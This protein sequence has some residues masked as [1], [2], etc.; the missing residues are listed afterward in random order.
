[1]SIVRFAFLLPLLLWTAPSASP[2][3]PARGLFRE[4]R[5]VWPQGRERERNLFVGFRATFGWEGN[6]QVT[7]RL[8]ASTLY[9]A[10]VNGRFA[11]YGPARGPHGYDRVD[12]WDV[13]PFLS[14][15]KSNVVAVEVAG[16]N[17]NSYYTLDAPSFFRAE[18][19]QGEQVL[20]STGGK[21]G[22]FEAFI[23]PERVQKVQRYSFQ[24][25]FS[26]VYRL[27][28]GWDRW[29][30]DATARR[31]A[32]ALAPAALSQ[33]R[34]TLP[35]GVANPRF[36][37]RPTLSRVASGTVRLGPLPEKP[38]KDRALTDVGSELGGYPEAELESV[39]SLDLQ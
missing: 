39:P 30:S 7:L 18:V 4:A 36:R 20:A 26:E 35:R 37:L 23:L 5:P 8:T 14:P 29:R 25:P 11:G 31:P 34:L 19:V 21:D 15:T 12:E 24:R 17:V 28:P 22:G 2:V 10:W 3:A 38:W 6:D 33:S 16:Y 27:Q 9:R 1:M 32:A 13:T